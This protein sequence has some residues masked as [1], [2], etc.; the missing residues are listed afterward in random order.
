M[1]KIPILVIML[2]LLFAAIAQSG[3][4]AK[5]PQDLIIGKWWSMAG[6]QKIILEFGKNGAYSSTFGGQTSKGTYKWIDDDTLELN[7]QQPV[8]VTV[9]EDELTM[10]LGS[11]ISKFQREKSAANFPGEVKPC[12]PETPGERPVAS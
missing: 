4:V 6:S 2:G 11:E 9:S 8:K 12:R 5:K 7:G 3:P 1:K 10:A